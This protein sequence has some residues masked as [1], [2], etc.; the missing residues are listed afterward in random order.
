MSGL[1]P[2]LSHFIEIA[3]ARTMTEAAKSLRIGQPALS[4]SLQR[5]EQ[6]LG[7]KLLVRTRRGIALTR[8]GRAFHDKLVPW[9][10]EWKTIRSVTTGVQESM[11]GSFTIA[12]YHSIGADYLPLFVPAVLGEHPGVT[13]EILDQ[14]SKEAFQ[15]VV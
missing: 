1:R 4:K 15:S 14:T 7:Y 2:E 5:L 9:A 12:C 3:R 13:F 11:R 8:A 6:E 10:D